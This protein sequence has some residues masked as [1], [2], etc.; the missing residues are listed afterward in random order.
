VIAFHHSCFVV[1]K[2][3]RLTNTM[4]DMIFGK[5]T[6]SQLRLRPVSPDPFYCIFFYE[7][8]AIMRVPV[9]I[10]IYIYCTCTTT[11]I[12]SKIGLTF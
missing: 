2:I 9:D 4:H 5:Y 6:N 10:H 3:E 7:N 11:S 12:L 8:N 1:A